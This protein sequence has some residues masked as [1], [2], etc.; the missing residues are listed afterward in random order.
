MLWFHKFQQ[1]CSCPFLFFSWNKWTVVLTL[2]TCRLKRFAP[3][4]TTPSWQNLRSMLDILQQLW[5]LWLC[6][7]KLLWLIGQNYC[8]LVQVITV[9]VIYLTFWNV[10]VHGFECGRKTSCG[11]AVSMPSC[12]S[13][14]FSVK[15]R[16]YEVQEALLHFFALGIH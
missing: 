16:G 6:S 14:Q 7:S 5:I 9:F 8:M 4:W 2:L 13:E 1:D 12:G 11:S 15:R 3:N 10:H